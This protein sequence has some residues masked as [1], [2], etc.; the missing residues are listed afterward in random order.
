MPENT[1]HLISNKP[2]KR[3]IDLL[4]GSATRIDV[5]WALLKNPELGFDIG[6]LAKITGRD[7][8][9]VQR[10]LKILFELQLVRV[11][12]ALPAASSVS[13]HEF[14]SEIRPRL[15]DYFKK[16]AV[17]HYY[18]NMENPWISPVRTLLELAMGGIDRLR[19]RL[20]QLDGIEI[21]FV[22]GSYA[23][24]EQGP[25]SDIDLMVIGNHTLLTLAAP[26]AE[27]ENKIGKEV[28]FAAYSPAEWRKRYNESNHFVRS[29]LETPKI[30]LIGDQAKLEDLTFA[31][32]D[33]T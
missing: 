8:K 32:R 28:D 14:F 18:L 10:A 9:D 1:Q 30:F 24:S 20:L 19:D 6:D 31:R 21:A 16:P 2:G 23:L 4:F 17:V 15:D 33:E 29:L 27:I 13:P 5:L 22:F 3:P 25:D 11:M 12:E 26:M 7:F